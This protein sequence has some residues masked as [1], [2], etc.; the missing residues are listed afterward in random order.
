MYFEVLCLRW[1]P[2]VV[3]SCKCLVPWRGSQGFRP[4][5]CCRFRIRSPPPLGRG[6]CPPWRPAR[7]CPAPKWCLR[8]TH[9]CVRESDAVAGRK[10]SAA[11]SLLLFHKTAKKVYTLH[12]SLLDRDFFPSFECLSRSNLSSFQLV[13]CATGNFKWRFNEKSF[14]AWLEKLPLHT[15][16]WVAGSNKSIYLSV[17]DSSKTP[18]IKFLTFG[19]EVDKNLTTTIWGHNFFLCGQSKGL[20]N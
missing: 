11:G 4:W 15:R 19:T 9:P 8:P 18:L 20:Y 6:I 13:K 5:D 12:L 1:P 14:L 10:L 2:G 3:G 17:L 16:F 7:S